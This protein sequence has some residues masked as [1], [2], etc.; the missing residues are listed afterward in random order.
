MKK[1][2]QIDVDQTLAEL[3]TDLKSGLTA[4]EVKRRQQEYGP[5]QLIERGM[6][7]PW[8]ILL[9]QFTEI[10]VVI[11]IIAALISVLMHETTDAIVILIIVVLNAALGFSQEYRA[12]KA[13]AALKRLSAPK[14]KV[15]RDGHIQEIPAQEL[16]PGDIIQ[17]DAGDAVAADCRLIESVNLRVQEAVL[18]GE[19]EAVEKHTQPIAEE[20]L[21][22]GDQRNMVFMGT[23]TTYGRGL[24][25]V[26]RTGMETELGKIA[27]MLQS[28]EQE[29]TPLQKRLKQLG[30]GL[31]LAALA[32]VV[33]IF[34]FGVLRGESLRLMFMTAIGMA[35]AVIPE[36]LPAVVTIALALGAQRMLKRNALIRKLPA[37]ETLGS[38]TVICSDKTGT[39]TENRMTVTVV[40]VAGNRVDFLEKMKFYSPT[41]SE[42]EKLNPL[43]IK[44]PE[45][46]LML[47][48]GALC[49][50]AVIEKE[51]SQGGGY[52]TVGDPTEGALVV[53]AARAGLWKDEL[54]GILPRIAELPFDSERKRMTTV[55]RVDQNKLQDTSLQS[56]RIL[57]EHGQETYIAFTKGAVDSLLQI[58]TQVWTE[59]RS[60]P[61]DDSWATRIQQANEDLAKQGVRVLGVAFR[62]YQGMDGQSPIQP[63]EEE[64]VFIGLFGMID[65]ARPEVKDAVATS[66]S[67]GVRPIMITGDHPLT[68]AHIARQLGI[69]APSYQVITGQELENMSV[70]ELKERLETVSIFARVSPAH[71][72][73]I[74]E[75]L[76][77]K[78]EIVAMTGDG[79]NDAPALKKADIG[80]AMGITGTD[81]SKE[82]SDMVLL[83]D[84]FATIVAAIEEGRRIYDNIRKFIQYTL[85]S[86][87]GEIWVMLLGPFF[88][89]SLPLTPLQIL[90]VN[91]VTDGLP[92]LALT[93]EPAEPDT[94]RRKPYPP[95]ENIFGR[96]LVVSILW[97]GILMGLTSLLAG[98]WAFLTQRY[99]SW[100]T[101][102]FTTLT[103]AQM[104]NV[105]AIRS[106][107]YTLRQIGLLSNKPLLGAVLLTLAL[108]LAVIY[109]PFLQSVFN[110]VPLSIQELGVSF[111]FS[112]VVFLSVEFV[113]WFRYQRKAN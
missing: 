53:A 111:A 81:V 98:I 27:D 15:R 103:L 37:V 21:P 26:V 56:I 36:G 5:N 9:D 34:A 17:L 76:Q 80:V 29:S 19:S 55:H 45:V 49:N 48:A 84:N 77:Q 110:T 94:M 58:S 31:A 108:Q 79:V 62:I 33:V 50:D 87:A 107:H 83:D 13:M 72:M 1:W 89:L 28:V 102:V 24:A 54:E 39:L 16:V 22:L 70:E 60:V 6:K 65:P 35:V 68:A 85:T 25:V 91:L 66:L 47:E 64:L 93:V 20:N 32:I 100:Q 40:D 3:K 14:V 11:L 74:V 61:L 73:K 88:G 82:A 96:G 92:G 18:T 4:A 7:S 67:A 41:V 112:I 44:Y 57:R 104:G 42:N 43:R 71:K 86:N 52:Q 105:L 99:A 113:K 23:V 95:N 63:R 30:K 69:G 10:M 75:A 59:G 78:G 8:R 97:I 12:E 2:H 109:L 106:H 51:F 101:M 38:V 90:W 46:S